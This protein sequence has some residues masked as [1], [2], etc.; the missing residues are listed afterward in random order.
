M[1][2]GVVIIMIRDRKDG[3][4]DLDNH[5]DRQIRSVPLSTDVTMTKFTIEKQKSLIPFILFKLEF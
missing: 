1:V 5:N 2:I 4:Q 3:N